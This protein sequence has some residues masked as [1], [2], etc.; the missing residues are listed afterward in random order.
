MMDKHP[1]IRDYVDDICRQ[2]KARELRKEFKEELAGHLDE[3][4]ELRRA[5]RVK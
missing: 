5:N 4:L 2:V 3:L 1:L